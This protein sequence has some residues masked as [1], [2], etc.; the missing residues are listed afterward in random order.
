MEL[1]NREILM[2]Y[3]P[4]VKKDHNTYLLA[5]QVTPHIHDIDVYKNKITET[6]LLEVLEKLNVA[7]ENLVERES[8][9]YKEKYAGKDLDKKTWISA[10]VHNPDMI[11]TPI[12]LTKNKAL[13]IETP[14]NVLG[15]DPFDGYD[16]LER[17]N[18]GVNDPDAKKNKREIK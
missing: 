6:Q 17:E 2:Y 5:K 15:L 7:V 4:R 1:S 8:D 9:V 18:R 10:L 12:V 16:K 3:K 13:L 14:S 11:K